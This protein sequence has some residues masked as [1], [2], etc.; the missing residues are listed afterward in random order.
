MPYVSALGTVSIAKKIVS[1]CMEHTTM[2]DGR[3]AVV[4]PREDGHASLQC[5]D[6]AEAIYGGWDDGEFLRMRCDSRA[7]EP[8]QPSHDCLS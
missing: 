8:K 6:L 4:L 3:S 2:L 1:G 7:S 5:S